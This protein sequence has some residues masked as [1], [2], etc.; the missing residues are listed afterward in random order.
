LCSLCLH[1]FLRILRVLSLLYLFSSV[2]KSPLLQTE[3]TFISTHYFVLCLSRS[4]L[5]SFYLLQILLRFIDFWIF[6][7]DV[8]THVYIAQLAI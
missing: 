1:S 2:L 8:S 7:E 3:F 6:S 5:L 4:F